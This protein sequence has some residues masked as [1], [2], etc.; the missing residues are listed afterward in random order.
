MIDSGFPSL[1]IYWIVMVIV[2]LFPCFVLIGSSKPWLNKLSRSPITTWV[3]LLVTEY[4][5]GKM[6]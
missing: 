4:L 5:V 1:A 2:G 6:L 3:E